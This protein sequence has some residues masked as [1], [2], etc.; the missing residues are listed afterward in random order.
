MS[1]AHVQVYGWINGGGNISTNNVKP[2]GNAPA[3]YDYT[4]NS[5]QLDQAVVY[6]ERLPDEVQNDH[7]DWGF[8][9]STLYGE[10]YRYTTAFGLMSYQ[11]LN[12]NLV[13]GID[14]P[15]VYADFY[16]PVLQGFNLRVGR[17]I[18]I[19]DIEAQ[20]A[21]NNYTYVHSLTYSWDNYTNTGV[22]GTLA[23]TKN[24]IA[25]MGLTVGSD[26]MPWNAGAHVPN[27]YVLPGMQTRS[28]PVHRCSRIPGQSRQLRLAFAG[29]AMMGGT[30]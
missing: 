14:F 16:F 25:Q 22:Q 3:A 24:W 15:M 23:V 17:F 19:P 30:T 5:V 18:S 20:L 13:Y 1:D 9:F 26:T 29:P 10:N 2:G 28:I 7:F 11:L 27:Y 8:R 21:P 12:H 6:V 4:P